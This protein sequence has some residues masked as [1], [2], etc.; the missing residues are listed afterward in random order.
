MAEDRQDDAPRALRRRLLFVPGFDPRRPTVYHDMWVEGAAAEAEALGADIAV[1]PRRRVGRDGLE[2]TVETVFDG[3][4]ARTEVGLLRWDDLVRELWIKGDVRAILETP[5]WAGGFLRSG[6]FA[7]ARRAARPL[8]LCLLTPPVILG[9]LV[10]AMLLIAAGAALIH[11]LAGLAVLAVSPF[12]VVAGWKLADRWI[13][14]NWLVQCFSHVVRAKADPPPALVAR[15]ADFA[16]RILAA[17]DEPD[18]D[19]VLVVGFS[20]GANLAARAVGEALA[21]R[22]DLGRGRVAVNL[23]TLG[24]SLNIYRRLPGDPAFDAAFDRVATDRSVGWVDATS[25]TD[26]ASTCGLDPLDGLGLKAPGRPE[27]RAPRFH[28]VLTPE[29]YRAIRRDPN[30]FHFQYLKAVDV[31]GGYDW[32][33]IA[34]GPDLLVERVAGR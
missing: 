6:V 2:W 16:E 26:P 4:A 12:A 20:L 18:V 11:P 9:L 7:M 27:R 25:A 10:L 29:R 17:A 5:V 13:N 1:G 32:F 8:Y 19:E 15:T 30:A 24:Q 21:A 14:T 33:R 28:K 22:P 23:L 34:A 3:R 31:A